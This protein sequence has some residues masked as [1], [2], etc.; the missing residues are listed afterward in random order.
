MRS[1]RFGDTRIFL[2]MSYFPHSTATSSGVDL[3]SQL[4]PIRLSL[5]CIIIA[6]Y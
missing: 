6:M 1:Y 3:Q 2:L 5:E 4:S